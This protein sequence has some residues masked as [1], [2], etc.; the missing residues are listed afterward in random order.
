[1]KELL[2]KG[3]KERAAMRLQLEQRETRTRQLMQAQHAPATEVGVK[4]QSEVEDTDRR[5][6]WNVLWGMRGGGGDAGASD[7]ERCGGG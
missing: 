6:V 7:E 4:L 3:R 1:M 5:G 2:E